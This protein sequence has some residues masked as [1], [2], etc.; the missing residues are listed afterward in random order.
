[1]S[2]HRILAIAAAG[3]MFGGLTTAGSTPAAQA[4]TTPPTGPGDVVWDWNICRTF[5]GTNYVPADRVH[6]PV[7]RSSS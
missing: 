3:L 4:D 7:K 6:V 1:M 5:C 2:K